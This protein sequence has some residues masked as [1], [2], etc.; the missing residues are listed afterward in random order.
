[1]RLTHLVSSTD[2]LLQAVSVVDESVVWVSGHRGTVLRT[3]DG[4]QSWER[5]AVQGADSLEFRDV[6]ASSAREAWLLS[7][8]PGDVSRVYHTTNGG[9]SWRLL[10]QNP[11]S[12]GFYDCMD[13]TEAGS[14]ILYGDEVDGGL[15]VLRSADGRSW[16]RVPASALPSAQEG[17]G[18]FAASGT[19]VL[20]GPENRAWIGTGNADSSRVLRTTDGGVTW[21]SSPVPLAAGS[22][23]GIVSLARDSTGVLYALGGDIGNPDAEPAPVAVSNDEGATW[24]LTGATPLAGAVYG[25]AAS[26]V[27]PGT[28]VAVSP[29]GLAVSRDGGASWQLASSERFWAVAFAPNGIGWAVGPRGAIVQLDG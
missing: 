3:T 13:F 21:A 4:G 10:H 1:M 7:S 26:P 23:A 28:L 2:A 16:N 17:E 22:G 12:S 20:A 29:R 9:S 6:H 19:C 27:F 11:D 5:L 25:A 8:G 18:G 14:G 15:V 24:R